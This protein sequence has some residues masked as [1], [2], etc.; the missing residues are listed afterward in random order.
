M[1]NQGV[2]ASHYL[3]IH[4]DHHQMFLEDDDAEWGDDDLDLL[5]SD[6]SFARHLGVAPGRLSLM[7]ARWYGTVRLEVILRAGPPEDDVAGWDNVAEASIEIRSG[8]LTIF[9]PETD[10]VATR[11]TLPPGTYRMRVYAGDI[12]SVDEYAQ[13]GQDYYRAVLWPAPYAAPA[14][15]YAGISDPW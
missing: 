8:S 3:D 1:E 5:Y 2:L 13:H 6:E 12:D 9:G 4:V 11:I 15:L 7:T 10:T 14:L